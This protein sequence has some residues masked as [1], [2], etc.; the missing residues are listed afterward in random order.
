M[1]KSEHPRG[2]TARGA[3]APSGPPAAKPYSPSAENWSPSPQAPPRL[4]LHRTRGLSGP[5]RP[6]IQPG[7]LLPLRGLRWPCPRAGCC[8]LWASASTAGTWPAAA[9]LSGVAVSVDS[10]RRVNAWKGKGAWWGFCERS[11]P[12]QR[13]AQNKRSTNNSRIKRKCQDSHTVATDTHTQGGLHAPSRAGARVL[14]CWV[15]RGRRS[16]ACRT[17]ATCSLRAAPILRGRILWPHSGGR[18]LLHTEPRLQGLLPGA[19]R[20]AAEWTALGPC[21]P[22]VSQPVCLFSGPGQSAGVG[23]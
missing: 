5:R 18:C 7:L 12:A 4:Q 10:R 14:R 2:K 3:A 8:R 22:R 9:S 16:P 20:A 23:W 17:P 13:P 21:W 15:R 19:G 1:P 6:R 11:C